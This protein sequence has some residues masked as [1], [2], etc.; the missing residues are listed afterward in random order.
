M[1]SR[2][3]SF[4][5]CAHEFTKRAKGKREEKMATETA[6]DAS[7]TSLLK[8]ALDE[9]RSLVKVEAALTRDELR[10]DLGL[11]TQSAIA[12]FVAFQL[13]GI[14]LLM[15]LIAMVLGPFARSPV[16]ALVVGLIC[17]AAAGASAFF[18]YEWRLKNPLKETREH[19]DQD[20]N[21]IK[22]GVK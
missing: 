8:E 12:G 2:G 6:T 5:L 3:W 17:L 20:L 7:I 21:L 4:L 18:G 1:R 16:A 15:L 9:S 11:L 13:G 19:L 22:E 10:R 14:G